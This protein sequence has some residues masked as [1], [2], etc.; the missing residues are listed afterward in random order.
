MAHD[1]LFESSRF[2]LTVVQA[3][4]INP[5]CFGE[6]LAEWLRGRLAEG[7]IAASEP[8]QEDWGWYLGAA[9]AGA[10][11]FI[12][13]GGNADE[14]AAGA[15]H[16]EWRIGVERVRSLTDKLLGRNQMREDDPL[17]SKIEAVLCAQPDFE[18]VRREG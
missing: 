9:H 5:C 17:L 18:N 2:N 6:D 14:P 10:N 1:L 12:A 4:F 11:Y 7:G 13:V 8:G 15:N 16:G 3:H